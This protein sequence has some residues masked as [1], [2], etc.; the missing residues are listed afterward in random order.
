MLA[1]ATARQAK[2]QHMT[3]SELF[4]AAVRRYLEE[5][6]AS[7]AITAYKKER[8]EGTLKELK[9]SLAELMA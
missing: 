2:R 6:D 1:K 4:R 8:K 5:I 3:H 7:E 9:G